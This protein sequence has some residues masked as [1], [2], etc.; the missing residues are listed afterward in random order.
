MQTL[1]GP[2][3]FCKLPGEATNDN[4]N[5]KVGS[6]VRVTGIYWPSFVGF[7]SGGDEIVGLRGDL[8]SIIIVRKPEDMILLAGP[9]WLTGTRVAILICM[10]S[11]V[12]GVS[13]LV[14]RFLHLRLDRQARP[15]AC[16][17]KAIFPGTRT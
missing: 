12:I 6:E 15:T 7:K 9:P 3:V 16:L 2:I 11:V 5:F 8:Q 10:L 4:G 1:E 14:I 13:L 17:I